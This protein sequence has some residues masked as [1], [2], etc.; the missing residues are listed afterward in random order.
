V[1]WMRV[2]DKDRVDVAKRRRAPPIEAGVDDD[3]RPCSLDEQRAVPMM[4]ARSSADPAAR[5]EKREPQRVRLTIVAQR[6]ARS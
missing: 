6:A 5:S 1:I 4:K 2:G 3:P